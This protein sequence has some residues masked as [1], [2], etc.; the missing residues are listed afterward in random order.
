MSLTM[1]FED[2]SYSYATNLRQ[3]KLNYF[4]VCSVKLLSDSDIIYTLD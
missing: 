2:D 3:I 1:Y 4:I